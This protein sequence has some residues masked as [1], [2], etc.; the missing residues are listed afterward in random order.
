[1]GINSYLLFEQIERIM[2]SRIDALNI[3]RN[4]LA[5]VENS[6][7]VKTK[8]LLLEDLIVEET[9]G[10]VFF[11]EAEDY[12]K[13]GDLQFL[14]AGNSPFIIDR[15][16]GAITVTGTAYSVDYYIDKYVSTHK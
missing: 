7:G 14:L 1:M 5:K 2:I 6:M 16:S 9:F 12:V 8:L 4:Y 3:A 11:Y 10:W 15:H 13:S